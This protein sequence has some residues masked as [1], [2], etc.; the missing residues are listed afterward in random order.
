MQQT[1]DPT[2]THLTQLE[3]VIAEAM[4][5]VNA[6]KDTHLTRFIPGN[7]DGHLHHLKF[8]KLKKVR[9]WELQKMIKKHILEIESPSPIPSKP[10]L[11]KKRSIEIKAKLRKVQAD[12]LI[13]VLHK[14]GNSDLVDL[15]FPP[16]SLS[17]VKK[18]VIQMARKN[19]ID[20]DLLDTYARLIQEKSNIPG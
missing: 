3:D 20:Q 7:Y 1:I 9:P 11:K 14:T 18:L 6:N 19:E 12:R 5:K 4:S 16:T 17:E 10:K 13:D 15:L 8:I 2:K